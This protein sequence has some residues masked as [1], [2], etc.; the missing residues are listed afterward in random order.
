MK[1]PKVILIVITLNTIRRSRDFQLLHDLFRDLRDEQ[2]S[3]L[4]LPLHKPPWNWNEWL[5]RYP[6][7][8][9]EELARLGYDTWRQYLHRLDQGIHWH[10][11]LEYMRRYLPSRGKSQIVAFLVPFGDMSDFDL[12]DFYDLVRFINPAIIIDLRIGEEGRN[13]D[14]SIP[15]T[16]FLK[17]HEQRSEF[18]DFLHSLPTYFNID[19]P[20]FSESRRKV[21]YSISP[22]KAAFPRTR[23]KNDFLGLRNRYDQ[24][25]LSLKL[26]YQKPA[27]EHPKITIA[28]PEAI[29]PSSWSTVE[30]FLY[31]RDYSKFVE[32]EIQRL[33]VREDL[34]YTGVSS[35]FPKSL[36][37][38]CPIRI[39]IQ[40]DLLLTNP[41]ELTINWYEPY[42]RLNFRISP[43]D[44]TKSEYSASIN[45]EVFADNLPVASMKLS[46]AVK[47]TVGGEHASPASTD[48]AWYEKIFASYAREDLDIVK[49]L[50][51]RYKA[52]GL[53]MFI[54][55]DDLRSGELW[56][57]S[58]FEKIDGSD[59]FQL[60]WSDHAR[61]SEYVTIEWKHALRARN[62]KGRKFIRPVYW[63][64]PIPAVPVELAEI[65]FCKID[66]VELQNLKQ[67]V[68]V[69]PC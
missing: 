65:N 35:E 48:A 36:P 23:R 16:K 12:K 44:N 4:P 31:L 46:I 17:Y 42:N 63:H 9:I 68:T 15:E 62:I 57:D 51:E 55:L 27:I 29:T 45:I 37:V 20:F 10:Q 50:K 64:E 18:L 25:N 41:S 6:D 54:D 7:I 32:K 5:H 33:K 66:F 49:H 39:I 52:L 28:Y 19:E 40:S 2:I 60:F 26:F 59:L 58:L 38:G 56:K 14:L 53:Y 67:L 69:A 13:V 8:D 34:D 30:I 61:K 1:D 22:E 43:T 47:E 3:I 21:H 11:E 24:S